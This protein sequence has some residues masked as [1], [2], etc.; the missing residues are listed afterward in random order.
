MATLLH[1]VPTSPPARPELDQLLADIC[2][3]LQLTATQYRNAEEKYINVG[4]WLSASDSPL[5]RLHPRIYAQ[6]SMA[7]QT[8]V[9]PWNDE[10]C[11]DLDLVLEMDPTSDNPMSLYRA[12][13]RRLR[14]SHH[15]RDILKPKKRCLCLNFTGDGYAFHMDILPARPDEKRGGTCIEIPDRQT[16]TEWQPSD[17]T[18]YRNWF[19]R[20]AEH[21]AVLLAERKQEPLPNN[22]PAYAKAV[23]KRAVQ[24]MKRRRD[25]MIQDADLAPRSVVLTTLA[26][27]HYRGER[28]VVSALATI[29]RG[30]KLEIL[31]ARPNRIVVCNPTNPDERFCESF[32]TDAQYSAFTRFVDEFLAEVSELTALNGLTKLEP[33]LT[34]MFGERMTK[35]AL[36]EYGNRI[37]AARDRG[38]VR[39]GSV[40]GKAGL[41]IG[42]G[43]GTGASSTRG[44]VETGRVVPRN[45][46]FGA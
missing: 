14:D 7:L 37:S 32:K 40:S 31:T 2:D 12:V 9:R 28:D 42:S 24:L 23:L 39:T 15:Y 21:Q 36:L 35:R 5:A 29:L 8:T 43:S 3:A 4:K 30:I 25:L 6:G 1:D 46:F 10:D 18:G 34:K 20:T 33:V 22:D 17:P 41:V 26:G 44:P 45:T 11:Y 13:E 38:E 16:P 27:M 19:D